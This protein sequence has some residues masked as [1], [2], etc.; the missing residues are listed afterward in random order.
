LREVAGL[1]GTPGANVDGAGPSR[2]SAAP[3]VP[4]G[5]GVATSRPTPASGPGQATGGGSNKTTT[6]GSGSSTPDPVPTPRDTPAPTRAPTPDPTPAPE[7]TPTSS[8]G[9]TP[10]LLV[11]PRLIGELRSDARTIWS[12]AG[13]TG[14]VIALAGHGNYVIGSQSRT[15]GHTYPCDSDLTIGPA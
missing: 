10:C 5:P 8:P 3:P 14:R 11:A 7:P 13:F 12:G 1:V 15:A 6:G 4:V 9:P 2:S